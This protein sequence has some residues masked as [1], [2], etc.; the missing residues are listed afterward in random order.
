MVRPPPPA[1]IMLTS[2]E[3]INVGE[4]VEIEHCYAVGTCSDGG[5]AV[6]VRFA[7]GLADVRLTCLCYCWLP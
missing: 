7:N 4:W 2:G 5:V 6:V 1:K 3:H